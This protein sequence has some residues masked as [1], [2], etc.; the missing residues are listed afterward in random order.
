[1]P[2]T[3]VPVW[4]TV[5]SGSAVA[6]V[7]VA[8]EMSASSTPIDATRRTMNPLPDLRGPHDSPVPIRCHRSF[9]DEALD[10]RSVVLGLTGVRRTRRL[11]VS[12]VRRTPERPG[13]QL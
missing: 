4:R 9:G 8:P 12:G 6:L 3:M 13:G 2:E 11:Q 10:L 5:V 1:M 7:A